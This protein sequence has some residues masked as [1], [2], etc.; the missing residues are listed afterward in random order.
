MRN[1]TK[2]SFFTFKKICILRI[3]T[4]LGPWARV[5]SLKPVPGVRVEA[6][7]Q[8]LG[9]VVSGLRCVV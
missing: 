7:G 4:C 9:L 8:G 1:E 3:E 6:C 2:S 5:I